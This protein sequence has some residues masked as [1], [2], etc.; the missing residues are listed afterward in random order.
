MTPTESPPKGWQARRPDMPA[1][2]GLLPRSKG[3][4]ATWGHVATRLRDARNYWVS[5]ATAGGRPHAMPVWGLW[6]KGRFVFSTDPASRK[7]RNLQANPRV[8]IHLESGDDV[9]V[10]EGLVE[11]V[12]DAEWLTSLNRAYAAKYGVPLGDGP[13]FQVVPRRVFSWDESGFPS[14]ATKWEPA[15]GSEAVAGRE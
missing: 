11:A 3:S 7:A 12:Q 10:V 9:V 14:T 6:A 15:G 13:V 1:G 8:V 2:Y 4:L 5:S